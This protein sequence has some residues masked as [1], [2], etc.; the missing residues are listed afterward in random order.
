MSNFFDSGESV[1]SFIPPD[2]S[3]A[4]KESLETEHPSDDDPDIDDSSSDI[5]EGQ[6]ETL[7]DN[8]QKLNDEIM[9]ST[10]FG[11][12][13]GTNNNGNNN[14]SFNF[15]GSWGGGFGSNNNNNNP[16]TSPWERNN[17]NNNSNNNNGN[18]WISA[19]VNNQNK[20][21]VQIDRKKDIV[22]C[23]FFDCIVE[24][25][26]SNGQAGL[27]PREIYDIKPRF[28]VWNRLAIFNP[29]KIYILY[30]IDVLSSEN[31]EVTMNYFIS[32]LEAFLRVPKDRCRQIGYIMNQKNICFHELIQSEKIPADRCIYL[33]HNSGLF[34][35]AD[36]DM[37]AAKKEEISY[38][39]L[40]Q[41]LTNMY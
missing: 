27:L 9:I 14:S 28:D 24:T 15:G 18:P 33:G 32:C 37:Q 16:P 7:L 38:L 39:D 17:N 19:T 41:F 10:P 40:G 23:S 13:L 26:Q 20:E 29:S 2:Y 21:M 8:Q 35:Q 11:T 31:C 6:I 5:D 4:I 22:I 30:P 25:Y 12:Q 3:D 34:C 1:K 36:S